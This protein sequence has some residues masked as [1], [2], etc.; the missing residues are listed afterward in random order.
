M[1]NGRKEGRVQNFLKCYQQ[2]FYSE[3]LLY[4]VFVSFLMEFPKYHR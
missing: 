3:A 2:L 4:Y 1:I